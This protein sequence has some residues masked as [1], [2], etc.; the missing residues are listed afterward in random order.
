LAPSTIATAPGRASRPAEASAIA[1]PIVAAEDASAALSPA[2]TRTPIR[3]Q[4]D[5]LSGHVHRFSHLPD[6]QRHVD[7]RLLIDIHLKLADKLFETCG[8]NANL[9]SSGTY[10]RKRII[11]RG[12]ARGFLDCCVA[13]FVKVTIAPA[14]APPVGSLILPST[15]LVVWPQALEITN[16]RKREAV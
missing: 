1:T 14:T 12:V 8:L 2:P 9:I 16:T 5:R 3:L 11:T 4:Q 6:A 13:T 7:T 15:A 10:Q